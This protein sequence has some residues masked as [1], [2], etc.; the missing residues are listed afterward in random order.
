MFGISIKN[1]N[2]DCEKKIKFSCTKNTKLFIDN[3]NKHVN[4]NI[5]NHSVSIKRHH[6]FFFDWYVDNELV[7][8]FLVYQLIFDEESSIIIQSTEEVEIIDEGENED[9]VIESGSFSASFPFVIELKDVC[10]FSV[11]CEK[12]SQ[13]SI[14][15]QNSEYREKNY[16]TITLGFN[17]DGYCKVYIDEYENGI[18]I[19]DR[20][21]NISLFNTKIGIDNIIQFNK[22]NHIM[23]V[24]NSEV[25]IKEYNIEGIFEDFKYI[26]IEETYTPNGEGKYTIQNI[27][28]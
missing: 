13:L 25:K 7:E 20:R 4:V 3:E 10:Q 8:E 5:G 2:Q 21:K 6:D 18:F 12:P 24:Y 28:D 16:K 11:L 14:F 15:F 9:V 17:K 26:Y 1:I 22:K 23:K 27:E 19:E